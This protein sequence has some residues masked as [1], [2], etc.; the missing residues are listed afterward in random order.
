MPSPVQPVCVARPARRPSVGPHRRPSVRPAWRPCVVVLSHIPAGRPSEEPEGSPPGAVPSIPREWAVAEWTGTPAIE[1][2]I[3][4]EWIVEVGVPAVRAPQE[5][6]LIPAPVVVV[7][8]DA[9]AER[10]TQPQPD[11]EADPSAQTER[12]V[13]EPDSG[14][15]P[16]RIAACSQ[17]HLPGDV[18][19]HLGTG[20]GRPRKYRRRHEYRSCVL[21]CRPPRE[22]ESR[23]TRRIDHAKTKDRTN[24]LSPQGLTAGRDCGPRAP[25]Q[26]RGHGPTHSADRC[27]AKSH[28]CTSSN[29]RKTSRGAT[30]RTSLPTMPTNEARRVPEEARWAPEGGR[31]VLEDRVKAL[32]VA[33]GD[34]AVAPQ[35]D[36]WALG[37]S[38]PGS[39]LGTSVSTRKWTSCNP[40]QSPF[41]VALLPITARGVNL[42]CTDTVLGIETM[43]MPARGVFR[44]RS[45]CPR[46]RPVVFPGTAP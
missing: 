23:P 26:A 11:S 37:H 24:P 7:H 45:S 14:N 18:I 40:A 30:V 20:R 46:S 4:Q 22:R 15:R 10:N 13:A 41:R 9:E 29:A 17:T 31:C 8:P 5:A 34:P 35:P 1:E 19:R 38:R 27:H 6:V 42:D 2:R 33:A 16:G 25:V 28:R 32:L 43:E 39:S 21:H 36:A 12:L 44:T 3:V